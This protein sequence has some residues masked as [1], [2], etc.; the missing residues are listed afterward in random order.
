[1]VK[2]GLLAVGGVHHGAGHVGEGG[3]LV[4]HGLL[5]DGVVV[6]RDGDGLAQGHVVGQHRVVHVVPGGGHGQADAV[7]RLVH[8]GGHGQVLFQPQVLDVGHEDL[9]DVDVTGAESGLCGGVVGVDGVGQ[10][11]GHGQ[12]A[13]QGGVLAPVIVVADKGH[14]L[15]IVEVG[16][17]GAGVGGVLAGVGQDG[18]GVAVVALHHSV[19]P[20]GLGDIGM[21]HEVL[22]LQRIGGL[23]VLRQHGLD[24]HG[25]VVDLLD[26]GD[27][28]LELGAG[29]VVDL[30]A[31]VPGA[32]HVVS[33]DGGAVVPLG[34]GIDLHGHFG[35]VVVPDHVA[36]GQQRG[37]A[38]VQQVEHVEGFEHD[39]TGAGGGVGDGHRVVL[40]RADG[41]VGVHGAPLLAA[42]VDGLVAGKVRGLGQRADGGQCQHQGDN[43]AQELLH[44]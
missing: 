41:V 11:L 4:G 44:V 9:A 28:V 25:V 21:H 5:D 29:A 26:A 14:D 1:M 39:G 30:H 12:L 16:A 13:P 24:H 37:D 15:V 8:V 32:H 34:G 42:E 2:H 43:H 31:D 6:H 27:V 7:G 33:G 10:I 38:A 36:V 20:R 17:V 3:G 23:A 40:V 35:L 19:D 18:G 22:D